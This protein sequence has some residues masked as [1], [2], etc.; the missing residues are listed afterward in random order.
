MTIIYGEIELLPDTRVNAR[1]GA[2]AHVIP[3]RHDMIRS[4]NSTRFGFYVKGRLDGLSFRMQKL[5]RHPD[6]SYLFIITPEMQAA[7]KKSLGD[8]VII[9]I[10]KD[11]LSFPDDPQLESLLRQI[12]R[13]THQYYKY[14]MDE[15]QRNHYLG[16][17]FEKRG[18]KQQDK[19]REQ[20]AYGIGLRLTFGAMKKAIKDWDK[21]HGGH[22]GRPTR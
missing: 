14:E 17:I 8:K 1:K 20:A 11:R 16:W 18:T 22:H 3:A 10:E 5:A 21:G 4:R 12:D 6:G 19:R 7:L 13:D 9:L 2:A 15:H